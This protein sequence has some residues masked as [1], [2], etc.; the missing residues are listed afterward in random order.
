MDAREV[1]LLSLNACQRQG[2][3]SDNILKK[4]LSQAGLDSRDGALATQLCFG[5]LQNQLLLDF[6]L[7]KF[8]NFHSPCHCSCYS[9]SFFPASLLLLSG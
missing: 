1:A 9:S 5:V 7:S 2:G 3:W 6:Y 4:Q 8:S